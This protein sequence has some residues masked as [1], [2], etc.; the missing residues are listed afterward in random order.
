MKNIFLF[1]L[2]LVNVLKAQN[3]PII[4]ALDN[5]DVLIRQNTLSKIEEEM[6]VQYTSALE[7]RI[8]FAFSFDT[9]LEKISLEF[10][11]SSMLILILALALILA[12]SL[13]VRAAA[14]AAA[15]I[16]FLDFL[17]RL[18][19]TIF[20]LSSKFII[21][22]IINIHISFNLNPFHIYFMPNNL[23]HNNFYKQE[24]NY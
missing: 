17:P 23:F 20:T 5:P 2:F 24:Y 4:E 22:R 10:V 19:F 3:D 1:I 18:G 13:S 9:K 21:C 7:K 12:L 6:L 16:S 15:S 11:F 14:A 8:M